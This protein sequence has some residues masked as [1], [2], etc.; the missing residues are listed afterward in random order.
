[1]AKLDDSVPPVPVP[2]AAAQSAAAAAK[3]APAAAKSA[4]AVTPV[5]PKPRT[6]KPAAATAV[7][8]A[9]VEAAPAVA[10]PP[11]ATSVSPYAAPVA[12]ATQA[13]VPVPAGPPQGLAIA[14]MVTGL[15]GLLFSL[16]AVGFGFLASVAAV[17]TG[18][19]AQKKQ[20]YAKGFWLTGIITGYIGIAISIFFFIIFIVAIA[21]V[22]S[23]PGY[24]Y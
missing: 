9:A 8:P 14:S 2:P 22:A 18:H 20:P 23:V 17:V 15:A 24:N 10:A 12:P 5:E 19:M 11:A 16:I 13:Y 4:P 3:S 21:F 1:M 6:R 7:A